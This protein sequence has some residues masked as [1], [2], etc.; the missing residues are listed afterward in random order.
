MSAEVISIGRIN[1]DVCMHVDSLPEAN[2][3]TMASEGHISFGGSATNFAAQ[4]AKLGMKVGLLGCVGDDLHGHQIIKELSHLKVDT[5]SIL[6]LEKQATGIFT[7]IQDREGNRQI[8]VEPGANRFVEKQLLEDVPLSKTR[9]IHIAGGFPKIIDRAIEMTITNGMILSLDPGRAASNIEFGRVLPHTDL[10]FVNEEELKGYF[11]VEA[12]EEALKAFAKTF[13]GIV[14]VKRG[15]EGAIATD[16]FE[17]SVSRAFP[18]ELVDTL[19]AG[20][21]F[22]A[23]FITAWT[24]SE[25][26]YQALNVANATAAITVMKT[27]AHEG[28]PDLNETANF[29]AKHGVN[30]EPVLRTFR[31]R[32]KRRR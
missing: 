10:L 25:R 32:R 22:A 16:G 28:Q 27:G 24:R 1:V 2:R 23:G 12:R 4:M 30:I 18:V 29:L 31:R 19:G 17:Y 20:D 9:T 15:I 7:I 13:P 21:S 14:I 11:G 5:R 3:H 26:L 6:V 8:I